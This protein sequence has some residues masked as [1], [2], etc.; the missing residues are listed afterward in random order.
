MTETESEYQPHRAL[1]YI[2]QA[3]VQSQRVV[4]NMLQAPIWTYS[5][6]EHYRCRL[7]WLSHGEHNADVA[8]L[9]VLEIGLPRGVHYAGSLADINVAFDLHDIGKSEVPDPSIWNKTED[10]L[11][12]SEREIMKRHISSA[13]PVF[14]KF[15]AFTGQPLP[16]VVYDVTLYHHEKLNGTG[17]PHELGEGDL[18]FFARLATCIDQIVSRCEDRSYHTRSYSLR[19]AFDEVQAKA[20]REFDSTILDGLR[21]L[22]ANDIHM[23]IPGATWLGSWE[24]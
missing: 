14:Y 17:K 20:G 12:A 3:H 19:E 15:E 5:D 4:D 13:L 24:S 10:E 6:T 7:H 23:Q 9:Y 11:V 16:P 21:I 1:P 2:E 8:M 22:F 18:V